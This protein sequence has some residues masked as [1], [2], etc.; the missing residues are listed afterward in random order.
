MRFCY[1]P[2]LLPHSELGGKQLMTHFPATRAQVPIHHG[3]ELYYGKLLL[4]EEVK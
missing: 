4:A 3:H 1:G 2:W